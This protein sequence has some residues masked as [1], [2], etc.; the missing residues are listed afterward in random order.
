MRMT[1]L[2]LAALLTLPA[3]LAQGTQPAA[4]TA[5]QTA[6]QQ[7]QGARPVIEIFRVDTVTD[8]SGKK[9][10]RLSRVT[11]VKPGDLLERVVTV[12]LKQPAPE[13]RM[14][15]PIP[16]AMTYVPGSDQILMGNTDL[17]KKGAKVWYALKEDG[18]YTAKPMKKVT[19]TEGGKSVER[20][21]A[22][23]PNEYRAVAFMLGNLEPGTYVMKHRVRVR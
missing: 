13:A 23:E 2:A 9:T 21:V 15:L 18:P 22:A 19:V 5:A 17:M 4:Q 20:E 16:A 10:E 3:A 11:S 14:K 12:T 6:A 7:S 1:P 8:A